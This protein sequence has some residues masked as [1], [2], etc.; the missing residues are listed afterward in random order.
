[1]LQAHQ[2]D[3][4]LWAIIPVASTAL[5]DEKSGIIAGSARAELVVVRGKVTSCFI[6][7]LHTGY[8][9]L[10]GHLALAVLDRYEQLSWIV[11]PESHSSFTRPPRST[12]THPA[13]RQPDERWVQQRAPRLRQPLEAHAVG[14]LSHHDRQLLLLING[15]R[16]VPDFCRLLH[17]SPEQVCSM[18]DALEKE[19]WIR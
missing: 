16:H 12:E 8:L 6:R 18:L 17:C 11:Q 14:A 3:G 9:V 1:M 19:G 13:P 5:L 7:D 15:V 2:Q 4:T 10:A